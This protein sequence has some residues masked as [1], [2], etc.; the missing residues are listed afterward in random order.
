M[1]FSYFPSMS[2]VM[3]ILVLQENRQRILD[4]DFHI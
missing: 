2:W 4:Q 1:N 3:V